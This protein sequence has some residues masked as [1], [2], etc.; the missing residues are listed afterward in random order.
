MS[1]ITAWRLQDFFIHVSNS[2]Y[3]DDGQQCRY[4][5]E[6]Y[7]ES[8]TRAYVCNSTMYGRFVTIRFSSAIKEHL[9]LC[10][11]QIMT[12]TDGTECKQTGLACTARKP[13]NLTALSG[14]IASPTM[15]NVG[16][17]PPNVDCMWKITV[18]NDQVSFAENVI[19]MIFVIHFI[20]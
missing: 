4:D 9:Q 1:H 20:L 6:P 18:S 13:Q 15:Y 16:N 5:D 14:I 8:E 17:Y 19:Q 11:V 2:T 3:D 7:L 10:E 12:R